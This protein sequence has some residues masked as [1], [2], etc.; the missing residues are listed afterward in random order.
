MLSHCSATYA[1]VRA[2]LSN[3]ASI[4][5][6]LALSG[7]MWLA[8]SRRA[9]GQCR[10]PPSSRC[11][12]KRRWKH[13]LL[14]MQPI[15][16]PP[17]FGGSFTS[18]ERRLHLQEKAGNFAVGV[19]AGLGQRTDECIAEFSPENGAHYLGAS[20]GGI[21][22]MKPKIYPK[23]TPMCRPGIQWNLTEGNGLILSVNYC[24]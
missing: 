1:K 19:L 12:D 4:L 17:I 6:V 20:A 8:T 2:S 23:Y 13:V 5:A 10:A 9:R 15:L 14:A 24:F 11:R 22:F 21:V 3:C 7:A 18:L 16:Q